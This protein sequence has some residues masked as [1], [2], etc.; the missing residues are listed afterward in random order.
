M[1]IKWLGTGHGK[2]AL[3]S[4]FPTSRHDFLCVG[5]NLSMYFLGSKPTLKHVL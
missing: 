4:Q 3:D 2:N 5:K 1:G